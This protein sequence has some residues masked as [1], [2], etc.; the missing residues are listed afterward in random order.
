MRKQRWNPIAFD[1]WELQPF[2]IITDEFYEQPIIFQPYYD[3]NDDDV[4]EA[5]LSPEEARQI[6]AKLI[7]AADAVEKAGRVK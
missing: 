7:E 5:R 4:L 6:A 1:P 3:E 2:A